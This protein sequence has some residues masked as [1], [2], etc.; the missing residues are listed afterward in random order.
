MSLLMPL[1]MTLSCR[2][3]FGVNGILKRKLSYN[4]IWGLQGISKDYFHFLFILH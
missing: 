1:E 4:I 3:L 2:S